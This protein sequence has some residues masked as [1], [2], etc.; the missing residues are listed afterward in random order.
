MDNS[1]SPYGPVTVQFVPRVFNTVLL[2][3]S[4]S[5]FAY[6]I[7]DGR[8]WPLDCDEGYNHP[9]LVHGVHRFCVEYTPISS[10]IFCRCF[11]NI[12]VLRNVIIVTNTLVVNGC[13]KSSSFWK[14][15]ASLQPCLRC[16]LIDNWLFKVFGVSPIIIFS[17]LLLIF[18]FGCGKESCRL[19]CV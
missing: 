16:C 18:S 6:R 11:S 4:H 1:I 9:Q 5:T 3:L 12:K 19:R 2:S 8:C 14:E 7:L 17:C 10:D 15:F 13:H